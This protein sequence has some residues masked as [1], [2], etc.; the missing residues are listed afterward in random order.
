[1]KGTEKQVKWALDIKKNMS[2]SIK[3]YI[4]QMEEE[5]EQHRVER[6]KRFLAK[7]DEVDE[8][9]FF[10]DNRMILFKYEYATVALSRFDKRDV[11]Q[12]ALKIA[13]ALKKYFSIE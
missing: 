5:G 8:A 6:Y 10:I 9:K 4:K 7:L 3:D 11:E 13:I 2:N 12:E 1:M